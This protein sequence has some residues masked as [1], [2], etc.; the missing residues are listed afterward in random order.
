MSGYP[1]SPLYVYDPAKP[2]TAGTLRGDR[3]IA[4]RRPG[5]QSRGNCC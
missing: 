1:V 5:G 3:V 4:R 2:W